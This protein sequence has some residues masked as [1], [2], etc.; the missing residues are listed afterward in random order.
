MELIIGTEVTVQTLSGEEITGEVFK[1]LDNTV[2][3]ASGIEKYVVKNDQL[4]QQ[5]YKMAKVK[6]PAFSVVH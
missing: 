6:R 3:V 1:I 4:K 5:G 2:I